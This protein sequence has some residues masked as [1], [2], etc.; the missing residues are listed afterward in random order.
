MN[1]LLFPTEVGD[2]RRPLLPANPSAATGGV[3]RRAYRL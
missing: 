3:S 1:P 2:E